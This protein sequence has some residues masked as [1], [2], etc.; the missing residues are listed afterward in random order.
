MKIR[1]TCIPGTAANFPPTTGRAKPASRVSSSG[2]TGRV[3]TFPARGDCPTEST[4][5]DYGRAVRSEARPV[6][7]HEIGAFD[8]FPNLAEMPKYTGVL[9]PRNLQLIRA[10]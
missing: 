8:V 1:G 3:N 4:D 5:V 2:E 7:V 6:V 9:K 10:D